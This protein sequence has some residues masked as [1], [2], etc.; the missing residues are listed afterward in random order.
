MD[1]FQELGITAVAEDPRPRTRVRNLS[2]IV[3][4]VV[5]GTAITLGALIALIVVAAIAFGAY[6]LFVEQNKSPNDPCDPIIGC[7]P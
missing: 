3:A 4:T 6:A 2:E 1:A 7:V 5:A